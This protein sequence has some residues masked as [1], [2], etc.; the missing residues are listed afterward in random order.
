MELEREEKVNIII[1]TQTTAERIKSH[2]TIPIV[3]LKLR[4]INLINAFY[5]ASK[6]GQRLAFAEY[7]IS[8]IAYNFEYVQELLGYDVRKYT[9]HDVRQVPEVLD[10][11]MKSGQDVIVTSAKCMI[12]AATKCGIPA[13]LIEWDKSDILEALTIAGNIDAVQA[14][15]VEKKE[16]MKA[17][18]N[19]S[20]NGILSIDNK[21]NVTVVNQVAMDLLDLNGHHID[22]KN[23]N[24]LSRKIPFFH[25][26]LTSN[27]TTQIWENSG[28]KIVVQRHEIHNDHGT[29]LGLLI[30][31]SEVKAIQDIELQTR[32]MLLNKG[33]IAKHTFES[34]KG[35]SPKMKQLIEKAKRF[36][37][38]D[39]NILLYGE[40]GCGK[41]LFAQSIHNFSAYSRGPFLAINCATLPEALLE[42]E[43][44]GYAEGAFT[45]AKKG[46]NQGLL[47]LANYGTLF[48]D[49]IGEMPL[50]L[51]SRLLRVLQDKSV[52]RIGGNKNVPVN[53]RIIAAT[54]RDLRQMVKEGT[55]RG[56][57]FYRIDVLRLNIPPLRERKED[58][59]LIIEELLIN[60]TR[61]RA[62]SF[63]FTADQIQRLMEY[64][65]Y[66]N[67]RELRNF[68][69]RV[70]ANS[71][72]SQIPGE[73]FEELFS[74]HVSHNNVVLQ[75]K[76]YVPDENSIAIPIG[77]LHEMEE[78]IIK[79]LM[80]KYNGDKKLLAY[81]LKLSDTTLWRRL[82]N[83]EKE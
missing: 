13:V 2:I 41:E 57:L 74:E 47:E 23:I 71:Q 12:K 76:G 37:L 28:R 65:W 19:S 73:D 82:K 56:D 4:D 20:A 80:D 14:K 25:A 54:N 72:R 69:E 18:I 81:R 26:I 8:N 49:E 77:S 9:F 64:N 55:F 43:L 58:I 62:Q 34:I 30:N 22:G 45:G 10:Q 50:S 32:K 59:P 44:F 33:F 52:R 24:S 79:T 68:V 11:I 70:L 60:F 51:Q 67:V 7:A 16:W 66:G 35:N 75:T 3:T 21:G 6:E 5:K 83:I 15:E 36:A 53:V 17:V 29:Q 42:S 63:A 38:S 46:G 40:S 1:T 48:L 27:D 61:E 31:L 39:S 78:S